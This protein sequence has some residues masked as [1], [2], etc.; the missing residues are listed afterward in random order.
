M[1]SVLKVKA[2]NKFE[3]FELERLWPMTNLLGTV[4]ESLCWLIR[5]FPA[6]TD[7]YKTD[8]EPKPKCGHSYH[9]LHPVCELELLL[10]WASCST[11]ICSPRM[12]VNI[13]TSFQKMVQFL[14][15]AVPAYFKPQTNFDFITE[16]HSSMLTNAQ[17]F[18]KG[19]VTTL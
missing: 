3:E 17:M 4:Y 7:D 16:I 14:A 15:V 12:C 1:Q 19:N 13:T 9:R 18:P 11:F 6:L 2:W 10:P 5:L 8:D